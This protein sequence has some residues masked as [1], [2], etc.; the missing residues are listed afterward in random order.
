MFIV[1]LSWWERDEPLRVAEI[2]IPLLSLQHPEQCLT[3]GRCSVRWLSKEGLR[4]V[5]RKKGKARK[6]CFVTNLVSSKCWSHL[7]YTQSVCC[8]VSL[9][10]FCLIVVQ[11]WKSLEH[12]FPLSLLPALSLASLGCESHRWQAL[13]EILWNGLIV[14]MS[15]FRF[16][17]ELRSHKLVLIFAAV[18]VPLSWSDL[19]CLHQAHSS[20]SPLACLLPW[21]SKCGEESQKLTVTPQDGGFYGWKL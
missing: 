9:H 10:H 18:F 21:R 2:F 4:T 12:W 15:I 14:G 6:S 19:G 3:F 16:G 13:R 17:R 5:A 1:F 7:M 20:P 11:F 8:T